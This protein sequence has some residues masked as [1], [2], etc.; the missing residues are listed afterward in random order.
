MSKH[1]KRIKKI[2]KTP[3]NALV[4]GSAFGHLSEYLDAFL[5]VFVH[6][7]DATR[8]RD[9]RV[10]YRNTLDD[11]NQIADVDAIFIDCD[12]FDD[13]RNIFT[14][15]RKSSPVLL[16]QGAI[17]TEKALQKFLNSE[18]YYAVEVTKEYMLWKIK[19]K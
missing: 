4:L 5:T 2:N 6:T 17:F 3:R 15:W 12:Y 8:I 7:K 9:K 11:L 19:S 16:T 14:V 1:A 10:V 13:I 18:H